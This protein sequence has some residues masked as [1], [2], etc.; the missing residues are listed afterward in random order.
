LRE[1]GMTTNEKKELRARENDDAK[2]NVEKKDNAKK[3]G[4]LA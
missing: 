2:K 1:P 3:K 4:P